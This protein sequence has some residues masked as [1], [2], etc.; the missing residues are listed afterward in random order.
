M[1]KHIN[2]IIG[3]YRSNLL[4]VS[5]L[6]SC[7]CL[8]QCKEPSY[9][10]D[11][12][13]SYAKIFMQSASNGVVEHSLPITDSWIDISF[14]AGY[15]G[16]L[17][18]EQN[19]QVDFEIAQEALDSYNQEN[20]T[21]YQLPPADSYRFENRQVQIPAGKSGS[22]STSI[23]INPLKLNGT[24]AYMLPVKISKVSANIA[25]MEELQT[26]YFLIQGFYESNPYQPYEKTNWQAVEVSSEQADGAGGLGRHAIDGSVNT[27]WLSRYSRTN[28]VRPVHPHHIIIDMNQS[29]MLHG[30]QIFGRVTNEGQSSQDYLFPRN[31]HIEV[32]DDRTNWT[33]A[34]L[35]T[36]VTAP[37]RAPEGTVYFEQAITG[38]YFKVTVL[39]STSANGDTTGIAE[40]IAF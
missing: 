16:P 6:M 38:R 13:E 25:V 27:V 1:R 23:S 36:L 24:R 21:N 5:A 2:K 10:L 31:I 26:T 20:N 39:S 32:S 17:L 18:L 33:S 35:F 9:E 14:G 7:I 11:G 15:G 12:Q 40:L 4:L 28:G 8:Q 3:K 30:L 19:V 22:N 29:N 34:G 37:A